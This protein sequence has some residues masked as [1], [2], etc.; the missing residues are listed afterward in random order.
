MV[1]AGVVPKHSK[2]PF[3]KENVRNIRE[4]I[5]EILHAA[6][7]S[8]L[9]SSMSIVEIL[10]AMYSVA[11]IQKIIAHTDDR[12][13]IIVSKGHAAAATYAVMHEFGL[14]D[15][16]DLLTYHQRG[17]KLQGHVSHGVKNVEHSTGALGHGLSVGVGH[18]IYLKNNGVN[19]R[20]MVLCGD[21][22]IQEGSVWEALMLA[23]TKKLNGL[24]LLV[25]VNG[26][27]SI[28][29]T[30][31]VISTGELRERFGGFGLRVVE[32]DGHDVSAIREVILT[33]QDEPQPLV[34]LCKTIK[35]KGVPFAEGEAIWHY[36]SLNGENY[37]LA[38][39]ELE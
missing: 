32:V 2:P 9:G 11:D 30:E 16:K 18:A 14:I 34:I 17:S 5:L 23:S 6:Q 29:K 4:N 1:Y 33:S 13:R 28:K 36:R 7:A 24:V 22:E 10:T 27:S 8:H 35:G 3:Y 25:D 19:A 12:D 38:L 37:Q 21:G 31:D 20:T 39:G 26:I 15:R